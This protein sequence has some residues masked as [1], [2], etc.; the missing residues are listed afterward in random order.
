MIERAR[1]TALLVPLWF[2]LGCASSGAPDVPPVPVFFDPAAVA[3]AY[4]VIGPVS[5]QVDRG[6]DVERAARRVFGRA[7]ARRGADAVLMDRSNPRLRVV[8]VDMNQRQDER[9][10]LEAELLRY[11]DPGC[12]G[13]A[14]H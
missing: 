8:R 6:T 14:A 1:A 10:T 7:G 3:C 2:L 5:E 11:S 4:D 9:I 13:A 12:G